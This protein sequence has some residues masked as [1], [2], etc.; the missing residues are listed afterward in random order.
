VADALEQ[1]KNR[2]EWAREHM[3]VLA[4]VRRD[5]MRR[6]SL[7]GVR[8][9]MAL[10]VEA[11]TGVLALAFRDAG[12]QVRLASCNPLS[13]DDAVVAGLRDAGLEVYAKKWES[14]KEYDEYL[15]KV[16]DLKPNLVIDDGAD[17]IYRLHTRRR[18]LLGD[19][20]GANEETT[21]GVNRIRAMERDGKLAFPVI[22]VNDAQMKHL[23]DNR[24]GTGQSAIDGILTATNL[25]LAGKRFV[26]AGYGWCGRG[27]AARAKG[28]G[29]H[30]VVTEV[31]PVKAIEAKLDG[32]EVM[33]MTEAARGAD[34][35]VTATGDKEVIT[36]KHLGLL[37]DGCIL[38]NAGHFNVEVSMADLEKLSTRKRRVREFV[39]EYTL[40]GDRKVYVIGEGRLVNLAAGQG[41]PVEI[42]DMSFSIQ[43]LCAEH[44]AKHG[45]GMEPRVHDV[46]RDIDETVAR[47]ALEA[48]GVGIDS[49]TAAQK[50]YL[51]SWTEG[52]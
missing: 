34:L 36:A 9:G 31:D 44:L 45:K 1:G 32:F 48:M 26:V 33:P 43:A 13:T 8:V 47:R 27:I 46:P 14:D 29:A 7:K 17:L 19:V 39:D 10:H 52:T 4:A 35:I 16:L 12:A 37:K 24:Y 18:D 50:A 38:A 22:D 15:H 28:M 20:I 5:L 51:Q 41:H 6:K 2:L 42:M 40:K 30:V 11:K 25:L 23:F 49:L 3:A 21:T